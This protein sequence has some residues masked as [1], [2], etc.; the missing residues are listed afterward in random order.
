MA[1]KNA[2]SRMSRPATVQLIPAATSFDFLEGSFRATQR[3]RKVFMSGALAAIA[4]VGALVMVGISATV[5]TA[6]AQTTLAGLQQQ[7]ATVTTQIGQLGGVG[8]S[9]QIASHLSERKSAVSSA[10]GGEV[11]VPALLQAVARSTPSGVQV[12]NVTIGA[13]TGTAPTTGG[14]AS[15][16]PAGTVPPARQLTLTGTVTSLPQVSALQSAL[17]AIPLIGDVHAKWSGSVPAVTITVTATITDAAL[18]P[19][20]QQLGTATAGGN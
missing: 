12:T 4:G 19:R 2:R 11:D 5:G 8:D 7:Q 13:A 15:P 20:A 1:P 6:D 18:T 9:Q 3:A 16:T 10:V 17:G 14:T